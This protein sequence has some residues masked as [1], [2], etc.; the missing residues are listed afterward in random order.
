VRLPGA[1]GDSERAVASGGCLPARAFCPCACQEDFE[2]GGCPACGACAETVVETIAAGATHAFEWDGMF[3]YTYPSGCSRRNC[4]A[5]AF[6]RERR[7]LL[8]PCRRKPAQLPARCFRAGR[9]PRGQ[10]VRSL[11][12]PG[13]SDA[14]QTPC[15]P[16]S[17]RSRPGSRYARHPGAGWGAARAFGAVG[18][19][20]ASEGTLRVGRAVAARARARCEELAGL[21]VRAADRAQPGEL[22]AACAGQAG[23]AT[24]GLARFAE[25]SRLGRRAGPAAVSAVSAR[26]QPEQRDT[27]QRGAHGAIDPQCNESHWL[28]SVRQTPGQLDDS[29]R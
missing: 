14:G 29:A 1:G 2:L 28:S 20:G 8:H 11:T 10:G 27:H 13:R 3:W 23:I 22:A 25:C 5:R 18:R 12:P 24:A 26:A 9:E 4:D 17:S 7:G 15:D 16:R 21:I 6:A 19:A